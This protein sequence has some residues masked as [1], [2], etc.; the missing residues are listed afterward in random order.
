MRRHEPLHN[1]GPL[2]EYDVQYSRKTRR[3]PNW[4]CFC[5][6]ASDYWREKKLLSG[7]PTP[8]EEAKFD[9]LVDFGEWLERKFR[10]CGEGKA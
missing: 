10:T 2:R 8:E 7:F 1:H 4:L 3:I 9:L 5:S 6:L